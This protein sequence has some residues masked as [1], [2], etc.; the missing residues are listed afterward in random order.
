MPKTITWYDKSFVS[1]GKLKQKSLS[2]PET[3]QAILFLR[4]RNP[5]QIFFRLFSG[6]ANILLRYNA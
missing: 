5:W 6:K 1:Y 3:C 2:P 4:I